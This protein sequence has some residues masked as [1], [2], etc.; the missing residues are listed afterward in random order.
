M[1]ASSILFNSA[2]LSPGCSTI[3]HLPA[4]VPGKTTEDGPSPWGPVTHR[5]DVDGILGYWLWS[6]S[7][8]AIAVIWGIEQSTKISL[9]CLSLCY[10]QINKSLYKRK[11]TVNLYNGM[12]QIINKYSVNVH[13]WIL[14][15]VYNLLT[16]RKDMSIAHVEQSHFCKPICKLFIC[17]LSL[18]TGFLKSYYLYFLNFLQKPHYNFCTRESAQACE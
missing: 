16:S 14:K 8:P 7:A 1:P 9:C 13:L 12:I 5:G 3:T 2:G 6:G 11:I 15:D 4:N 10:Y 17:Y 18:R